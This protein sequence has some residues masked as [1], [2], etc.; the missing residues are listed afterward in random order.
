MRRTTIAIVVIA[1]ISV[2][3]GFLVGR[4]TAPSPAVTMDASTTSFPTDVHDT[5]GNHQPGATPTSRTDCQHALARV[6]ALEAE[7][8]GQEGELDALEDI[9]YG[10][11]APAPLS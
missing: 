11:P 10:T 6:S 1:V 5:L 3:I 7:A 8:A 2:A 4:A 9:A